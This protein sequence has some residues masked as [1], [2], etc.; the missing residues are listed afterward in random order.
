MAEAR[1]SV[2]PA[3]VERF[4]RIAA[5]WWD[6]KGKFAPLHRF[7][8]VR[9]SFIREQG[10]AHFGRDGTER[11][12]FEGLRLLD[13]GC[14][15][16]LLSEPMSRLGFDVTG[17]DA[18]ERNIGTG[19]THAEQTGVPVTYLCSTAEALEAEGIAP[20]DVIL[21]MEVI[22]H[23]ADPG[24]FLRTCGRLLAPGGLMIVATLNRTLRALALA[25]IGAEYVLRW[26]PA[27]THD[28]RKFL[29]PE[30]LR[31]FLATEPLDMQG[32]F[33]VSFNPLSG[34]WRLSSDSGVNYMMTVTRK[35]G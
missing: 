19:R 16:G 24:E 22:E 20:F 1:S 35:S 14:G 12:P 13:I 6:P 15:G 4:S 18:S 27:G 34:A 11:Q 9:L 17:V 33:G 7:N 3:E 8:P 29:T 26:L 23:V 25:K 2:D 5:E 30:E 28:W 32:P 31:G 10:L 21:N